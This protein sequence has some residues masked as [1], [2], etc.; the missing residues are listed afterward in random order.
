ML[1]HFP[2]LATCLFLLPLSTTAQ[3]HPPKTTLFL[4]TQPRENLDQARPPDTEYAAQVRVIQPGDS[5]VGLQLRKEVGEEM[6]DGRAYKK[7]SVNTFSNIRERGQE[8]TI[9]TSF[10]GG[11][12]R[13][14]DQRSKLVHALDYRYTGLQKAVLFGEETQLRAEF[15]DAK[16]EYY[17]TRQAPVSYV[18]RKFTD[19]NDPDRYVA[20]MM[21]RDH[22][23]EIN[24]GQQMV[25]ELGGGAWLEKIESA[26]KSGLSTILN[27]NLHVGDRLQIKEYSTIT[28]IA[29]GVSEE[30]PS[31]L[32]DIECVDVQTVSEGRRMTFTKSSGYYDV[33][34]VS[35]PDTVQLLITDDYWYC[36]SDSLPLGEFSSELRISNQAD[37]FTQSVE[38]DTMGRVEAAVVKIDHLTK[39]IYADYPV[40]HKPFGN[41]A[42]FTYL[43]LGETERGS[44]EPPPYP[45]DETAIYTVNAVSSDSVTLR[46]NVIEPT[47]FQFEVYQPAA[48]W[49]GEEEVIS[50]AYFLSLAPGLHTVTFPMDTPLERNR[51]YQVRMS[52]EGETWMRNDTA[53]FILR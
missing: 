34:N 27:T 20:M 15:V 52:Y 43:K 21:D 28:T 8:E 38:R 35:I 48:E 39:M 30:G 2:L 37:L 46:I 23:L 18:P 22:V 47:Q 50:G 31:R 42:E 6:I 14:L 4:I 17:F 1:N 26:I 10:L 29:T 13:Q 9:Y 53:D 24:D 12:Y 5:L 33:W 11:H 7:Y 44:L 45:T 40:P 25:R 41:R 19:V 16:P 32:V 3:D 49:E 51:A 36:E